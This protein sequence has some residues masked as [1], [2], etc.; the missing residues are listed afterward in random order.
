MKTRSLCQQKR[1]DRIHAIA[2][3]LRFCVLS[4]ILSDAMRTCAR[5]LHTMLQ[6]LDAI[7]QA[8]KDEG[9]RKLLAEYAEEI[10]NPEN[11]KVSCALP[12]RRRLA[13]CISSSTFALKHTR[14]HTFVLGQR[15]E[16][17]LRQ[18][19]AMQGND[20]QFIN[21]EPGFVVKT[22]LA[23]SGMKVFVNICQVSLGFSMQRSTKFC[24]HTY[25]HT[26]THMCAP[27]F[28]QRVSQPS[29][30]RPTPFTAQCHLPAPTLIA[31][32][33]LLKSRHPSEQHKAASQACS[34]HCHIASQSIGRMWTRAARRASCMMLSSTPKP[35]DLHPWIHASKM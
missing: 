33:T 25:A 2:P 31:R 30:T 22:K 4:P 5:S 15:Y 16:E 24:T 1:L 9:F 34:G 18:M 26:R 13:Q 8:M 20:V 23:K 12:N 28:E 27:T 6:E 14:T 10:S 29:I 21:P 7:G 19:E 35:C 11:R 3:R 17:E 32:L